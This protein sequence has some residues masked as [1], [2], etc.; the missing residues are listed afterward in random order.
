MKWKE[1]TFA[2]LYV[3]KIHLLILKLVIVRGFS[4]WRIKLFH[5]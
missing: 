5:I 4:S 3:M 2:N 1:E